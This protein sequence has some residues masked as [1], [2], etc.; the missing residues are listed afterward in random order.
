MQKSL[1]SLKCPLSLFAFVLTIIAGTNG[2]VPDVIISCLHDGH[3][4]THA[5]VAQC[6]LHLLLALSS[7]HSLTMR[8]LARACVCVSVTDCVY[9][10]CV[11]CIFNK[12]CCSDAF[13]L[14]LITE[15]V[16]IKYICVISIGGAECWLSTSYYP[17]THFG[18]DGF[19][20]CT[21]DR[22]AFP[23]RLFPHSKPA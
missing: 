20:N 18:V 19:H 9:V 13:N 2:P 3:M 4:P 6:Q 15:R 5:C 8:V 1:R 23:I 14:Q 17:L 16:Q 12:L 7:A 22:M 10:Y 21:C 11:P